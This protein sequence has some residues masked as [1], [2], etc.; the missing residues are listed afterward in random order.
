MHDAHTLVC[1]V[2][3]VASIAVVVRDLVL[4]GIDDLAVDSPKLG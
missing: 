1:F 4:V 2:L 3:W